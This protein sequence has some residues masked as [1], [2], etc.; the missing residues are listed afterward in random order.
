[1]NLATVHQAIPYIC[2]DAYVG[3]IA[4]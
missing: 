1:L 3:W 4:T 2:E